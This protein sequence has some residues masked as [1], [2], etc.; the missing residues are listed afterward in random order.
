MKTKTMEKISTKITH[1]LT[2]DSF[3]VTGN[4]KYPKKLVFAFLRTQ[5]GAGV[6]LNP[7]TV[8]DIYTITIKLDPSEDIF[9]VCHDCGNK[10]LRDGILARFLQ[11]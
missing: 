5:I 11:E 7:P 2:Q 8:Q 1:D 9:S 3:E 6:D 4:A 10:G